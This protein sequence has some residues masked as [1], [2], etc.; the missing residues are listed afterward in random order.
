MCILSL[1]VIPA[2]NLHQLT[3]LLAKSTAAGVALAFSVSV[4]PKWFCFVCPIV[5]GLL[6]PLVINAGV[7]EAADAACKAMQ[8]PDDECVDLWWVAAACWG[9]VHCQG[10][11][12]VTGNRLRQPTTLAPV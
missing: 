3:S 2:P 7:G 12:A 4:V 8:L 1:Q 10:G 5:L 9:P 11:A 6:A